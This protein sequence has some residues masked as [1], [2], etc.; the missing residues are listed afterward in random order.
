LFAELR[1]R[2]V[3]RAGVFYIG[4]V[5]ALTQGIAQLTP[6][7]GA[8]EWAAR[9]FLVA[10]VI[11]FPFWTAFAWF[12]E[13]T[14]EGLKRESE[15][16][17]RESITHHTGRKLD[18][19][20]I[21]VLIIA[22]VLL[23]T[24]RFVLHHGVNEEAAVPIAEHSIA[25]LP[26]VDMSAGKDQE[27]MSDGLAEELINLLVRIPA[28]HVT[29][30]S[31]AFSFKGQSLDGAEIAKRLHV[32][33]ILEGSVRKAG[34]RLRID[35][36]LID[37][38]TD[39]NLWSETYQRPLDDIFAVQ[40]EIAAAV[41][42]Q[43]K[44][45]LLRAVPKSEVVDTKAYALFLQA[46][47]LSRLH[48][49]EG[50]EQSN[51]LY[52]QAL[53]IDVNYAPAWDGLAYNY[54]RQA[55]NGM[56]PLEEGYQLAREALGKALAIDP[57][58][59]PSIAALGRIALDHDGDLAAAAQDLERALALSPSDPDIVYTAARVAEGLGRLP[60]SMSLDEY[61]LRHDPVNPTLLNSVGID[62]RY[63]GRFDDSTEAF[64]K[65]LQVSPGNMSVHY[66]M[67]E[68]LLQ[69]GDYAAALSTI[70]QESSEAWR[71]LGLPM[72]YRGLGDEAKYDA[73][74]AD[75]IAIDAKKWPAAIASVLAFSGDIDRSF[76]WLEKA[77]SSHDPSLASIS[78][79]SLFANLHS[80]ARWLPFLRKIGRAP[81]QLAKI[82]FKVKLPQAEGGTASSGAN[83]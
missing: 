28:L 30:R 38:R 25:V 79:E 75:L 76:E 1:R 23:L 15:V 56:R 60:V 43:L 82:E 42:A 53:A 7:V 39:T 65:V 32:A 11:G 29:S 74:I 18:F 67:G 6:V 3:L 21:G 41:V 52:K 54:R 10:A 55:N 14:P 20:I 63:A 66:R 57:D 47:P 31:S 8:P 81:E 13:F 2:N 27:Y 83:H 12:Y 17:P 70:Q 16:E 5:W 51:E 48:T 37:A 35:A 4:A 36:Q 71:K 72:A 68:T 9:W 44:I 61:A 40:D 46:R 78:V 69:K 59:A 80:D 19:A 26:F 45:T 62:Y 33:H 77:A 73:A 24:D 64:R 22:V 58:Y 34:D 49:P 50:Y